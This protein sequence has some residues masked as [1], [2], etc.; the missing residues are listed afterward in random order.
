MKDK[1]LQE[2]ENTPESVLSE[3]LDFLQFVKSK[4]LN[5][6]SKKHEYPL[7]GTI[8]EYIAPTDPVALEDWEA[9]Q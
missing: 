3:V 9:M 5:Q 4:R 6:D 1:L 8:I 7:R 2:I